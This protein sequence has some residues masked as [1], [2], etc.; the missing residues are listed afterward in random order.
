MWAATRMRCRFNGELFKSGTSISSNHRFQRQRFMSALVFNIPRREEWSGTDFAI[1]RRPFSSA[2]AKVLPGHSMDH[3]PVKV[4]LYQYSICPFCNRVKTILDYIGNDVLTVEHIEVNPLTKYEIQPWKKL[5]RKV[6]IATVQ[7]EAIFGSDEIIQK[8]LEQP[9]V[10]SSLEQRWQA[11]SSSPLTWEQFTTS[12][13]EWVGFSTEDLAV[14]LYPNMCRTWKDSYRAF[15]YIHEKQFSR[16][17]R[18]LIQSIG[19][20]VRISTCEDVRFLL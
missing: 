15:D 7:E 6:P 9:V 5:Y 2:E 18:F 13:Q 1:S 19:S 20:L 8:V 14:W 16:M 10:R 4:A 3:P 17:Q 12:N 11:S